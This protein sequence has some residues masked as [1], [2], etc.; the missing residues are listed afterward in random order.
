MKMSVW[1]LVARM[2][3][4]V[5]KQLQ[6]PGGRECRC[7]KGW[8]RGQCGWYKEDD[9]IRE[10]N[11]VISRGFKSYLT[12]QML[13]SNLVAKESYIYLYISMPYIFNWYPRKWYLISVN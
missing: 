12:N 1:I 11:E 4:M 10:N 5:E 3:Y 9:E 8:Q 13:D 6:S 7:I 2:L